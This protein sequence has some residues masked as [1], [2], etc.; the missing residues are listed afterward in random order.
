MHDTLQAV[1]P[2]LMWEYGRGLHGGH[3]LVVTPEA[4]HGLRPLVEVLIARAPTLDGWEFYG[5]RVREPHEM[6]APT[7]SGRCGSDLLLT[8]AAA[9]RGDLNR[10]DLTFVRKTKL[11]RSTR[12]QAL[13]QAFVATETLV[14]EECMNRWIGEIDVARRVQHPVLLP[15]LAT[16]VDDVVTAI[17]DSLPKQPYSSRIDNDDWS[18]LELKPDAAEDYS[19]H[20]DLLVAVTADVE[21]WRAC[22]LDPQFSSKRFSRVGEVFCF[23]KIDGA[24]GLDD[25]SFDDRGDIDDA[26]SEALA[27]EG[28]GCTI[29][30]GTGRRYSYIDLAVVNPERSIP[31]IQRVLQQGGIPRRSWILFFDSDLQREWVRVPDDAPAPP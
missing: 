18:M 9:E 29:G 7:I 3:R 20:D 10:V 30:G 5:H 15:A 6:L 22:H 28:L 23:L 1:H 8:A 12:N 13:E 14:G 25:S 4:E 16:H 31:L 21:L 2:N 26:V 11:L 17:T 24:D 27:Q 19:R